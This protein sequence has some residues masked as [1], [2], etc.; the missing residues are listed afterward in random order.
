MAE[1]SKNKE[2]NIGLTY[3]MLTKTNYTAWSMKMLVF[4]QAHSVWEAVEPKDPKVAVEDKA[5]K[6]ALAMIYQSISEDLLLTLAERKTAKDA[7]EAI[8]TVSL[9]AEKVK[10]A[11]AQTLKSEFES[12]NMKDSAQ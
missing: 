9:G 2:G 6:R 4:M 3:P 10:K 8:K 12:L 1:S 7:W 5:D 11:K